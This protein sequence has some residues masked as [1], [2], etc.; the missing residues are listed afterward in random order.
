MGNPYAQVTRRRST[1]T[2]CSPSRTSRA[3]LRRHD[4]P[5]ITDGAAAVVL[6]TRRQGA[7]A[8]RAPGVD[9]R[10]RPPHRAPLP[11][12]PRPH[13]V[14]VDRARGARR[15]RRRRA[16]SRSPSSRRR[17]RHEE[18]DPARGARPR[19]RRRRQP[20]GRRA[21][22]Q[23]D[24]GDRPRPHRRG[25]PADH[26]SGGAH[27]ALA[28]RDVG[29][30][31]ATEPRL[32]PGRGL[33]DGTQPCARRR[34]R[35]DASTRRRRDDVSLAGLVREAALPRA[36][37]RRDD[38][39]RHRRRRASAR[40]PTSFEGVMMPELYL[41]DALGAAGKP[42]FRVHTAGTV[43]GSTAIVAVAPRRGAVARARARGRV[44]EA[45]R[46]QR[47]VGASAAAAAA[48][49]ARAAS[50]APCI[51][52]YISR[53]GRARAHRLEGRGQ[54]PPERAEE[55]V[56]APA[57]RRTSRIEKVQGVADAVGP[58]PL[59]RVVPV[60]RRRVRGRAHRRGRRRSSAPRRRRRG[61]S[62]TSVRSELGDVPGPRP[63]APAGGR[64]LRADVYEQAGITN[65][66]E[67][68]DVAELYVP[69]SL[70]RADVARGPRHRRP[71]RGL[72]DDRQR[73]HRDRR[74]RSRSTR[75]AA[76]CR[77]T[78]SARRACSAS[79]RPRCRCGARPASTRSTGAKVA[80]GH[81][82]GASA[83]YFAM[84]VLAKS[85]S[86]F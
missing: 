2:S 38:V 66:R 85:P 29:A 59:P 65:P 76:C 50:F 86:P 37:R 41:A 78:R 83:Q 19:R 33:S 45:V 26:A 69:F 63:G 30:V 27:R 36:R 14:A 31:P 61:S 72:E 15:R 11:R 60:V 18:L 21:R 1:S 22:R 23:P 25:R 8:V 62:A 57:A 47:A 46:G 81:A 51:R 79:P 28:P 84:A 40:R 67:Q 42:M 34:H 7:R 43:G 17:S 16:R 44:R 74:R 55:P 6:A 64:R 32:R 24:H 9:H 4:L 48:A 68:I 58:A 52:A 56:R 49:S 10:L 73:R 77:R 39:E 35:P 70:V 80:L 75:R 3:P 20:V 71:R 53:I 54:G 13:G 82:Y 5:P 12:H